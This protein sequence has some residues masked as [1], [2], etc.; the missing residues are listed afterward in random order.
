M[1][2][3]GVRNS[4]VGIVGFGRIAQEVAKRLIPF[5]PKKIIYSNRSNSREQEAREI[6]VERVEFEQLLA[7]SDFVIL[8][9]IKEKRKYHAF[10]IQFN[11]NF[12]YAHCHQK[13]NI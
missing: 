6:G 7:K 12:S 11:S 1:C 8:V 5:K 4:T 2:G 13:H 9:K 10:S 3:P